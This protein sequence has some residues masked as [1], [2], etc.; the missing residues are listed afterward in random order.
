LHT[1]VVHGLLSSVQPVP[2]GLTVSAAQLKLGGASAMSWLIWAVAV[3]GAPDCVAFEPLAPGLA[4][5][6][7]ALSE[8]ASVVV[9]PE[10]E[11]STL[12]RSVMPDGA[13]T[14]L[15][16]ERP[17]QPTSIVLYTVVVMD[18]VELLAAP[19]DALMGLVVSTLKYALIPPAMRAAGETVKV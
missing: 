9:P 6:T 16:S 2:A 15:L 18:G 1:S 19:P 13:P 11:L 17:K 14:A 10:L 3:L 12:Y 7:S 8:E 5:N 4:C